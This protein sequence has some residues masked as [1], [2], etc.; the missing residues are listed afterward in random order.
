M[1]QLFLHY[2]VV[3]TVKSAFTLIKLQSPKNK[4]LINILYMLTKCYIM[5]LFIHSAHTILWQC[6]MTETMSTKKRFSYAQ[7]V[8]VSVE[9]FMTPDS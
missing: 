6:F 4:D 2:E 1:L 7:Y 9:K 5:V 3:H 8:I